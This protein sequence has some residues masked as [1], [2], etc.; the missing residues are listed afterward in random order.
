M[1]KCDESRDV[2]CYV[3]TLSF[4]RHQTKSGLFPNNDDLHGQGLRYAAQPG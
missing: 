2:A 3:S 1:N 4:I